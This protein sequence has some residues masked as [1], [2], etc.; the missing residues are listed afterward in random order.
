MKKKIISQLILYTLLL[1]VITNAQQYYPIQTDTAKWS[2]H[3]RLNPWGG[4]FQEDTFHYFINGDTLIDSVFYSKVYSSI[5]Y[6]SNTIDTLNAIYLGGLREDIDKHVYFRFSQDNPQI[7]YQVDLEYPTQDEF[8]L[9]RFD[10]EIGESFYMCNDNYTPFILVAI[11]SVL[12]ENNYRKR[13]HVEHY[14]LVSTWVE[15]IGS[16][17]SLFGPL[18][19]QFEG[20]DVL[21]CYE[22]PAVFYYGEENYTDR[23]THF[24]VG[25]KEL[26][27]PLFD[28]YPNP[29]S[30]FINFPNT[31]NLKIEE[32][33]I[34]NQLG[35]IVLYKN[36][37]QDKIDISRLGQGMYIIEIITSESKIRRK[38]IIN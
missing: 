5:A 2:V 32:F 35:D 17:W 24:I 9:Y 12:V 34:Y 31:E 36:I 13:Y 8:L 38:L 22:D 10:A 3:S 16:D 27:S 18:C 15:G 20:Y 21:L 4:G 1:T 30:S 33:I 7:S 23:C 37:I 26:T 11:D 6:Y 19:Q 25:N 29:A 28:I 14:A